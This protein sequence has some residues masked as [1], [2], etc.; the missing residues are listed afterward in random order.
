MKWQAQPKCVY[1]EEAVSAIVNGFSQ[2]QRQKKNCG[3]HKPT[4][5]KP[6]KK[7]RVHG[8][9]GSRE[10]SYNAQERADLSQM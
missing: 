1:K 4:G 3:A 2:P 6:A 9:C 8:K 5:Y 7:R 10:K